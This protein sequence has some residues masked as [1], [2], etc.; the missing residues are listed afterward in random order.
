MKY[1]VVWKSTAQQMLAELWL[2]ATDRQ[3]VANAADRIDALLRENPAGVG[4][5]RDGEARILLVQPL[6]VDY[7]L[8]PD[9][10][11]VNVIAVWRFDPTA[12]P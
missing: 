6:G 3:I 9:D 4:E 12:R 7:R 1:T 8:H 11:L 2:S 10:Q 5:S